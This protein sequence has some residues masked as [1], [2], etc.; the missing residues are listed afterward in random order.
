MITETKGGNHNR[1]MEGRSGSLAANN[2]KIDRRDPEYVQSVIGNLSSKDDPRDQRMA[3]LA[4]E[5]FCSTDWA[6]DAF[7]RVRRKQVEYLK[8]ALSHLGESGYIHDRTQEVI[9]NL[10][11]T[12]KSKIVSGQEE[13][14]E[15]DKGKSVLIMT[16]HPATFV[17]GGINPRIELGIDVENF[18][19]VFPSPLFIAPFHPVAEVLGDNLYFTSSEYP[20]D[21]GIIHES[22]GFMTVRPVKSG[23]TQ[24]LM[25]A[26]L[27]LIGNH[28]NAAIVHFAEGDMTGKANEGQLY[29]LGEFRTGGLVIAA[30]ASIPVLP[31]AQYFNPGTGFE[32]GVLKPI[33]IDPDGSRDYFKETASNMRLEML[34]WLDARKSA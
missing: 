28:P 26:V 13:L 31:V 29:D 9:A 7:D 19:L 20:L 22:A 21:L 3:K 33:K 16:N 14:S 34:T 18:D 6:E 5:E 12:T 2:M 11:K 32:I 8:D 1:S 10:S 25:Q 4:R 23:R 27:R 24:E 17:L 15:L 30:E